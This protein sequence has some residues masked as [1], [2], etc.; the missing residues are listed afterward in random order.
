MAKNLKKMLGYV[1]DKK[2]IDSKSGLDLLKEH[3]G[4]SKSTVETETDNR[5]RM[6]E[7]LTGRF[8]SPN[9]N[10]SDNKE[11]IH[12]A[13]IGKFNPSNSIENLKSFKS[14]HQ[15]QLDE[16]Q[17]I[18]EN[19]EVETS[20]LANEVL[21]LEKEKAEILEELN[22]SKWMEN[23]V[24]LTTKK[25]YEDKIKKIVNEFESNHINGSK[26]IPL[27]TA[28]SRKRQGNKK[29]N[30]GDWLRI[31]E[32]RYLQQIDENIAKK[33]FEDT[34]DLIDRNVN[35]INK[36]RRNYGGDALTVDKNYALSFSGDKSG[37]TD[38][39]ATTNFKPSAYSLENGLTISF[40]VRPDE[41]MTHI[42]HF[43]GSRHTSDGGN[44]EFTFGTHSNGNIHVKVGSKFV[45]GIDNP[46]EVG[47]WYNW[48]FTYTGE[49]STRDF[50]DSSADE[51]IM[52][53]W[54]N[55]SPRM[56]SN[57]NS[58]WQY[59]HNTPIYFG[60]RN[61]EGAGYGNGFACTIDN[62]AIYNTSFDI[63]GTFANE[64]Y[65]GGINYDHLTNGKSGLVGYWKFDEG[66]GTIVKD[67]SGEGNDG[68]F[69]AISGQTT[70]Y[71]TWE[72]IGS[73][74]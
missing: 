35:Y 61:N 62:V 15:E 65:N 74:E 13:L 28:V 57:T 45:T 68:E 38:S 63:D 29:L 64:V 37:A 9:K 55:N 72:E 24:A 12:E 36:K 47:K 43:L 6:H 54:V 66:S 31:P 16:K 30:W 11:K 49:D 5:E 25:M 58:R 33:I 32:N 27:L 40:W 3:F 60:G 51:R 44:M 17:R 71:P 7:I 22:K 18:I 1:D 59:P 26:I 19:L 20:E 69:G 39:Y 48:V 70:A 34:N 73:Y 50:A 4:Y 41:T 67:L 56:T 52:R 14:Q 2:S 21:T 42:Q 53:L 46:M 10:K 8:N 23:N